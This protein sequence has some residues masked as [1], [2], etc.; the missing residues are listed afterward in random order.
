M[1]NLTITRNQYDALLS[2]ALAHNDDQI[3]EL[4]KLID[5]AN[6][7]TR[8]ILNISWQDIGGQPPARISLGQ[9]WPGSTAFKLE[10]ER[11][12]SRADVDS[13]LRT[14]AANPQIVLVTP[15]PNGLVGWTEIEEYDFG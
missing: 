11:K 4:K 10:L 2:A 6:G 14:Q 12:I 15:D 9:G 3:L 5:K 8:Y 1:A 13:V 7:I